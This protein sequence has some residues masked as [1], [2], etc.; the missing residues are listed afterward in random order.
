MKRWFL[1]ALFCLVPFGAMAQ[2]TKAQYTNGD[3]STSPGV[4]ISCPDPNNA[5]K[6]IAC[7][8]SGGTVT[9]NQG[10]PNAGGVLSW[11]MM[12]FD[13][14]GNAISSTIVNSLNSLNVNISGVNGVVVD[15]TQPS[16]VYDSYTGVNLNANATT[17]IYTGTGTL[18][19]VCI[20]KKGASAN[21]LQFFDNTAG[22]GTTITGQIDTTAGTPPFCAKYSYQFNT[23]LTAVM[24]TGTAADV[25]ITYI[26]KQ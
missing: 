10:N 14:I 22:S 9:A 13:S 1:A 2:T 3:G 15:P 20:N 12:L 19:T 8:G 7:P 25:S 24:A 6:T 4:T 18:E 17:V 23:G 26:T 16:R 11:P 21:T 5:G